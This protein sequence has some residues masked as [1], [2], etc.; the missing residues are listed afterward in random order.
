MKIFLGFDP[1]G[2]GSFGWCVSTGASDLPLSVRATGHASSAL[3]AIERVERHLHPGEK[4]AGA[5]I[6]APL[7]WPWQEG[8]ESDAQLRIVLRDRGAPSPSGSV[9]HVNSLRG[10]CA[11]QGVLLAMRLQEHFRGIRV[12]ESHPKALLWI[13]VANGTG[14]HEL[15]RYIFGADQPSEHR[16]DSAIASL[17][18]W[19]AVVEPEGWQNLVGLDAGC[20]FPVPETSFWMPKWE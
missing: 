2:R 3:D 14:E 16:R 17:S 19:A 11:V 8:R 4:V 18:A 13:M 20:H 6:D 1:G 12:T 5:G 7:A 15:K 9:Q 10:A